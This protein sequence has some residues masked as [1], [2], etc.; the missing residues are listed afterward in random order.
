MTTQNIREGFQSAATLEGTK[1]KVTS[2]SNM[3]TI[4]TGY[5]FFCLVMESNTIWVVKSGLDCAGAVLAVSTCTGCVG[6][7]GQCVCASCQI[8]LICQ[9][10]GLFLERPELAAQNQA[11]IN[12]QPHCSRMQ[13]RLCIAETP[14]KDSSDASWAGD[15]AVRQL[16]TQ[17]LPQ[18]WLCLFVTETSS[19]KN[20]RWLETLSLTFSFKLSIHSYRRQIRW[21]RK[22][23]GWITSFTSP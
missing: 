6:R 19:E 8:Q 15:E 11:A 21:F 13:K 22:P 23:G 16:V 10:S 9:R 4:Y 5:T 20:I 2:A 12:L 1:S 7:W 3:L 18:Q 14:G 17:S